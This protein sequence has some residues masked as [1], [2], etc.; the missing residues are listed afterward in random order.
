MTAINVA[1]GGTNRAHDVATP[2]PSHCLQPKTTLMGRYVVRDLIGYDESCI[3]YLAEDMRVAERVMLREYYPMRWV[4]RDAR[5]SA[6]VM[7]RTDGRAASLAQGV[8]G[9]A[10]EAE[11]FARAG[12]RHGALGV[13]EVPLDVF[14][15]NG[16]AYAVDAWA[17]PPTLADLVSESDDLVQAE[18]LLSLMRPLLDG[19]ASLHEA[20]LTH[21][22]VSPR[23]LVARREG[24]R[25]VWGP[26]DASCMAIEQCRGSSV[27]ARGPWTDVY[28]L[29]ATL[30][31]CLVGV[32]PP[33][34]LERVVG[35]R[36]AS[37]RGL[38]AKVSKGQEAAILKGLR[39]GPGA[40]YQSMATL[41]AALFA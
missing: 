21:G 26:S 2:F 33:S 38:G 6:S 23:N 20:G 12:T 9:F 22:G 30:Y 28:G 41:G 27:R 13:V 3:T 29:C 17:A 32:A 37:P 8:R 1:A 25:L 40:R 24:V 11:A 19:L 31:S 18:T 34:A 7:P 36:I 39:V 35:R 14:C 16:T 5:R 15:Q 4:R 10:E